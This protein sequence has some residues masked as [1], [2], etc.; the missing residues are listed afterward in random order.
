MNEKFG[1][2]E[3]FRSVLAACSRNKEEALRSF[4]ATWNV[5]SEEWK[6]TQEGM[7]FMTE[8]KAT[9]DRW[10]SRE[11][12]IEAQLEAARSELSRI[13]EQLYQHKA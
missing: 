6:R 1:E 5:K 3:N 13:R 2:E 8:S 4:Y 11:G 10:W 12:D 9:I 7:D